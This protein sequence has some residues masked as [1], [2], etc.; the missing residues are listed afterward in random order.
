VLGGA[1]TVENLQ[2]LCSTCNQKKGKSI[3]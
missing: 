3:G 1:H 2:I